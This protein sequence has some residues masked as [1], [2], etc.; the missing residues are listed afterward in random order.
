MSSVKELF[1]A[2]IAKFCPCYNSSPTYKMLD[3]SL[4]D[5]SDV[6][7]SDSDDAKPGVKTRGHTIRVIVPADDSGV[8]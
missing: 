5:E 1:R 8:G 7:G 3:D 6:S 2:V 4:D